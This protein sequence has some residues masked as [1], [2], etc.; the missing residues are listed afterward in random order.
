MFG[1]ELEMGRK[2]LRDSVLASL[3]LQP[4]QATELRRYS[5]RVLGTRTA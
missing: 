1:T 2:S 4:G 5:V 3:I